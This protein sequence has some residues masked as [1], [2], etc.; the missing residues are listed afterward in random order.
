MAL[1][2]ARLSHSRVAVHRS[3]RVAMA[4]M[5]LVA[6]LLFVGSHFRL[7][8]VDEIRSVFL[9]LTAPVLHA[10]S[11]IPLNRVGSLLADIREIP[12]QQVINQTLEAENR[13]L[14]NWYHEAKRLEA[15]NQSLRALLQVAPSA[16][17]D[18]ITARV[19]GDAGRAFSRSLLVAA[20]SEL[21]IGPGFVARDSHGLA[22]RVVE[23]GERV[24]RVL[25]L[26]DI[27]SRVPVFVGPERIPAILAGNNSPSPSL[28]Y[29]PEGA[30]VPGGVV[31]F[32]SGTGGVFPP[33]LVVGTV[34]APEAGRANTASVAPF[35]ETRAAS[36]LLLV[37]AERLDSIAATPPLASTDSLIP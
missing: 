25:L 29:L 28:Q 14:A 2:K 26:T 15:E 23:S 24:S 31:V 9:D 33:D 10:T 8:P 4:S 19:L 37:K 16:Q 36:F 5:V 13:R 7:G 18:A 20:G 17:Q 34:R 6:S 27:N 35:F 30:S 32:T 3:P 12:K 1:R 22:G 21:G 11:Q